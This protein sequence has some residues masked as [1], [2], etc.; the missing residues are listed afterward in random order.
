[1]N[2]LLNEFYMLT[3]KDP[4]FSAEGLDLDN[5]YWAIEQ[6]EKIT[7]ELQII[8]RTLSGKA[9]F[10]FNPLTK[11]LHPFAFLKNFLKS[12]RARRHFLASPSTETAQSMISAYYKTVKALET[13][14][15]AYRSAFFH[16]QQKTLSRFP[17]ASAYNFYQQKVSFSDFI[18]NIDLMLENAKELRSQIN[19]RN[20]LLLQAFKKILFNASQP[21]KKAQIV[22][23]STL[24]PIPLKKFNKKL[25]SQNQE[26]LGWIQGGRDYNFYLE[27]R[28]GY[29][30]T[31]LFGPIFYKLSQFDKNP[32]THEFY[33]SLIKDKTGKIRFISAILSDEY[34]F[35]ELSQDRYKFHADRFTYQPLIKRGINFWYQPATAFYFTPDLTYYPDLLTTFD[36]KMRPFLNQSLLLSQKSSLLDMLLWNGYFHNLSYLQNISSRI[37]AGREVGSWHYLLA[38][39]SYPSLYYLSFNK[40]V[41]RLSK[42][43]NFQGIFSDKSA[44]FIPYKELPS[45]LKKAD[46]KK[47]FEG[48]RIRVAD[49]ESFLANT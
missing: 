13:D 41:W 24:D 2:K 11:I 36:L 20:T 1:M 31:E 44:I 46:L 48:G 37:K 22:Y 39:R 21:S 16:L 14:L 40:S 3:V 47:I 25:S 6:L 9:Y 18:R 19:D 5:A 12:E 42:N 45:K 27:K 29:I 49:V 35:L 7:S 8:D 33:L 4:L 32:A 26:I 34:H 15:I 30:K 38:G 28:Y 17:K 23:S 10:F 43:I